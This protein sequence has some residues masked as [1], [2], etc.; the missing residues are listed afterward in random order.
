VR[1]FEPKSNH[2]SGIFR[3]MNFTRLALAAVAATIADFVYGFA[4]YG[5]LLTSSFLEQGAIYRSAE[6]QMSYMPIGA[7]GIALAMVAA[8][9]LFAVSN[10]RGLSGGLQFGFL[11]AVFAIGTSVVVGYA[12]LNVTEDHAARMVLAVLGEWLIAGAV[13]GGIYQPSS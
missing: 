10:F 8:A 1:L 5:N 7:A 6:A 9:M 4:V 12:T 2:E 11:L 3:V 13:I